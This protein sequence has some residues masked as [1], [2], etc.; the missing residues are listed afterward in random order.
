[1]T[2]RPHIPVAECARGFS[3][4]SAFGSCANAEAEHKRL[5]AIT[6]ALAHVE[7]DNGDLT[8]TQHVLALVTARAILNL[9]PYHPRILVLV[10]FYDFLGSQVIAALSDV[11]AQ[12]GTSL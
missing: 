9:N 3:A 1:M 5:S 4:L 7:L 6:D 12:F 10:G 11:L 8:L 2:G